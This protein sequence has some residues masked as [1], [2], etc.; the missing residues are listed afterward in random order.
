MSIKMLTLFFNYLCTY[1]RR[2]LLPV[3]LVLIVA[4]AKAQE[5]IGL[6]FSAGISKSYISYSTINPYYSTFSNPSYMGS[7]GLIYKISDDLKFVAQGEFVRRSFYQRNTIIT[8]TAQFTETGSFNTFGEHEPQ[9]V[10]GLRKYLNGSRS[11]FYFQPGASLIFVPE[12][13]NSP[14]IT[15]LPNGDRTGL[16]TNRELG[17]ALRA[18]A[19]Y[20]FVNKR[21]NYFLLGLRFQQG[22]M[23][24]QYINFTLPNDGFPDVFLSNKTRGSYVSFFSTYGI[25]GVNWNR[26]K[27]ITPLKYYSEDKTIKHQ[28][29]NEDGWY[30]MAYGG[31]RIKEPFTPAEDIYFNS[32]GQ[33][34][35]VLG[36]KFGSFSLESGYGQFSAGNSIS[37]NYNSQQPFWTDWIV[38]GT[39]NPHIP[40]TFKCDIPISNLKT[41][42]FGPSFSS[43]ILLKDNT[44]FIPFT[45][46]TNGGILA[47]DGKVINV[48]G[49]IKNLPIEERKR[50]FFNA[51][52][53][54]EFQVFN[55]SFM[56]LN[57]TRNFGSP[58]ISR[59]EADYLIDN[60]R[61]QFEQEATLN[62]FRFDFGWKLPLNILDKQKKL[63]LRK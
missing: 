5:N 23:V 55:S 3:G 36:Y 30:L 60:T 34:S 21:E 38:Y 20:S 49:V 19:G 43:H 14:E 58:V 9:L 41:L 59:F 35:A 56:S 39:N 22:L 10:F 53:H 32:S 37:I 33:F 25:N 8:S 42:R 62:G 44:E 29:A 50:M 51:G 4:E 6:E 63:A 15:T 57:V 46:R 12:V 27:R 47:E 13:Y 1:S 40:L 18:D 26:S 24:N 11:G 16:L 45:Y 31:F 54:L 48:I 52:M 2:F 7:I 61:I 17:V 28:L